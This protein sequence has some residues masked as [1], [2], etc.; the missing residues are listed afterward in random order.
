[1]LFK[2][3]KDAGRQLA[4]KLLRYRTPDCVLLALP[5]GGVV[6][7]H[8]IATALNILL[9]VI[10]VRKLGHPQQ[11]E[12]GIG[13]ISERNTTIIDRLSVARLRVSTRAL[14]HV[15]IQERKELARRIAVYRQGKSLPRLR[16]KNVILVDDGIAT[17]VT[18]KAAIKAVAKAG[19]SHILCA[20]PVTSAA[21]REIRTQADMLVSLVQP[22]D[23]GPI[24]KYYYNF[25]QVTDQQVCDLLKQQPTRK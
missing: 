13:A 23:F 8:E 1:M 7:A 10:V 6:V 20:V 17:G 9:S 14:R 18:M 15:I 21:A 16:G 12:F 4:E 11:P 5:R 19:A 24:S 22:T 25:N 3:R 2:D